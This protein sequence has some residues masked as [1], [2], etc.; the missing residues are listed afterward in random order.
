[1][2]KILLTTGLVTAFFCSQSSVEAN[3]MTPVGA[4]TK[5]A[6]DK[7]AANDYMGMSKLVK[8]YT[9]APSIQSMLTTQIGGK[10]LIHAA[11]AVSNVNTAI[12]MVARLTNQAILVSKEFQIQVIQAKDSQGKTASDYAAAN[13]NTALVGLLS[14]LSSQ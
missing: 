3:K 8:K 6:F 10:T 7:I 12:Q 2:K 11:A 13:N 14:S 5:A 1:M 4:D 9:D